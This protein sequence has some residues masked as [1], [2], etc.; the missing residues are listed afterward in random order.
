[1]SIIAQF[2]K[3]NGCEEADR[4]TELAAAFVE[5]TKGN[6]VPFMRRARLGGRAS[7]SLADWSRRAM[8][9]TA[10]ECF[11]KSDMNR[12][13]AAERVAASPHADILC[14]LTRNG[15]KSSLQ[16]SALSWLKKLRRGEVPAVEEIRA[17]QHKVLDGNHSP[18]DWR[19]RGDQELAEAADDV[20]KSAP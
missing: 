15:K 4:F 5:L 14:R 2:L 12:E 18:A 20:R 19:A 6:A 8:V 17:Y 9:A 10:M 1:L 11:I 7:D 13:Q 3:Q 16:T